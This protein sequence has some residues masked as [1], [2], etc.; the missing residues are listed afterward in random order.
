VFG[1]FLFW[2]KVWARDIAHLEDLLNNQLKVLTGVLRVQTS[3]VLS[4]PPKDHVTGL[5]AK[6]GS[7]AQAVAAARVDGRL[8]GCYKEHFEAAA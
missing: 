7:A 8:D 4:S 5:N 1:E 6:P 3:V 2:L